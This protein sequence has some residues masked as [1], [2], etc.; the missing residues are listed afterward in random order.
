MLAFVLLP[1]AVYMFTW[2][3]WFHHFGW[4]WDAWWQNFTATLN[5]HEH[6]L[7]WTALDPKTGLQTPT[8]P[9][10]ARQWRWILDLR[11]TSF[12]VK[13]LGP[14][15]EQVL[16][17]GNP[18]VFWVSVF[19]SCSRSRGDACALAGGFIWWPSSASTAPR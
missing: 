13:D 16:A 5:F 18:I 8:H 15:I 1:F 12:Y 14:D 4:S 7:N 10:Y 11:P 17:I 9:Y 6:G 3:P 2:I 19:A